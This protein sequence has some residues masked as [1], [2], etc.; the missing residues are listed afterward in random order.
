MRIFVKCLLLCFQMVI[1]FI[2]GFAYRAYVDRHWT[3]ELAMAR[4]VEVRPC[5]PPDEAERQ[6]YIESAALLE[7]LAVQGNILWL[8]IGIEKFLA[9]GIYRPEEDSKGYIPVCAPDG[10]YKR[11]GR[12]LTLGEFPS[13]RLVEYNLKLLGKIPDPSD[14]IVDLVAGSA[15]SPEPQQSEV[16]REQDLRPFARWVLGSYR[17]RAQ[18]YAERAIA[19]MGSENSL[20][21]GAAQIAATSGRSDVLAR[22]EA[23]MWDRLNIISGETAV[24]Y[25]TRNRLYELA[26]ALVFSGEAAKPFTSAL[27]ELMR[28]KVESVA[29]PFGMIALL[30]KRMCPLL[31][32]IEGADALDPFPYCTDDEVKLESP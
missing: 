1:V 15:F 28:R 14:Y 30:P 21:T 5:I 10:L 16:F 7:R 26:Y 27:K 6:I 22:V 3:W 11:V 9:S 20:Q 13:G 4:P 17:H 23:L 31:A 2:V 29:P 25:S 19:E 24:P 32:E 18:R 8:G 12:A